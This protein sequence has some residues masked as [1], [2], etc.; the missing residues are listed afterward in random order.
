MVGI[1]FWLVFLF[2]T[3][4]AIPL[5]FPSVMAMVSGGQAQQGPP[6][7]LGAPQTIDAAPGAARMPLNDIVA[8]AAKD[9]DATPVSVTVPAQP[10]RAVT[11]AFAAEGPPR[12]V[13]V[14]PYTGDV[15]AQ[16][17][18]QPAGGVDRRTVEQ[19]HGGEALG[20][21]WKF[22]VFLSGF[23]PL[24]FVVTGATMWF[25]KRQARLPMSQPL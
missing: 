15:L 3:V 22:L 4:T 5:G 12:T 2:V 17:A 16:P 20:P 1:W 7:G 24:I 14:N 8:A 21:V 25:K 18:P 9:A 13:S 6:P 23:L 11:V 19:W 10:D